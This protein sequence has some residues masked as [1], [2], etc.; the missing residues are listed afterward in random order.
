MSKFTDNPELNRI[1]ASCNG[2][3]EFYDL[4]NHARAL[5]AMLRKHEWSAGDF[6]GRCPECDGVDHRGHSP[7]CELA[8]L[9]SE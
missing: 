2:P 3:K 8:R 4:I 9:I 7:D 6:G 1:V 5:E